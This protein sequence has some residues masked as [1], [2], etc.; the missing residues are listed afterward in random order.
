MLRFLGFWSIKGG[1]REGE[2]VGLLIFFV[3]LWRNNLIVDIL[4]IFCFLLN[5]VFVFFFVFSLMCFVF[6]VFWWIIG[7]GNCVLGLFVV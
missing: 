3:I 6:F 5:M 4:G 2:E 7:V 1:G